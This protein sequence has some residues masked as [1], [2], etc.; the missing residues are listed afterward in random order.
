[1]KSAGKARN[2]GLYRHIRTS[3][4]IIRNLLNDYQVISKIHDKG[5]P[6]SRSGH[7]GIIPPCLVSAPVRV[8]RAQKP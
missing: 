4:E 1:M 5:A 6:L 8:E 7:Y 2:N 3:K